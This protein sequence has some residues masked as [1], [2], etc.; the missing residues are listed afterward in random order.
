MKVQFRNEIGWSINQE[1]YLTSSF[2]GYQIVKAMSYSEK[3]VYF[4]IE[5]RIRVTR[6]NTLLLQY[7]AQL[8]IL[9]ERHQESQ[10]HQND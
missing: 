7:A 2:F 6:I 8:S 9:N 3:Q 10:R 5:N 1:R 4:L